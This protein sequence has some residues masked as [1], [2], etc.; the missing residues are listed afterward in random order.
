M[1]SLHDGAVTSYEWRS[2]GLGQVL[3]LVGIA[4]VGYVLIRQFVTADIAPWVFVLGLIALAA[5]LVSQFWRG[6]RRGAQSPPIAVE[7]ATATIMVLCGAAGSAPSNGLLVV[8]AAVGVLR[9]A[10]VRATPIWIAAGVAM[11]AIALIA[12]GSLAIATT[13]LG[14]L[15]LVGGVVLGFL[16]GLNRRQADV[17]AERRQQL[18]E[19]TIAARAEHA[20]ASLLEER[21]AVARD[22]HDVLA[23]SLGGLV[24]QLDAAEALLESGRTTDA[25]TRLRD[26]RGLAASGLTEARRAVEALREARD[27]GTASAGDLRR[28]FVELIDAHRSMG[29][30]IDLVEHGQPS[31][32]DAAELDGAEALAVRR[33]LQEALSNARKHAPGEPVRVVLEWRNDGMTIQVRNRMADARQ[34]GSAALAASGGGHGLAGMAERFD[35][36][37][38]SSVSAAQHGVDFVVRAELVRQVR[39]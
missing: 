12:L 31:E 13:P 21:Q 4:V 36:L 28:S 9:L 3:S 30:A 20:K 8:L 35:A 39:R 1:P 15:A 25:A 10:T 22:I 6:R 29:G 14:V 27:D 5:W 16:G 37:E 32:L 24:I 18:V 19:R 38:G 33:A 11:I 34:Q 17:A 7:L 23:H 26:A 2:G